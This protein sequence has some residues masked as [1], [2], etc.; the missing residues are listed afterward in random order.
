MLQRQVGGWLF[1]AP[2]GCFRSAS[3]PLPPQVRVEGVVER[4]PEAESTEYFHSRPRGS[5]V[6][7]WVSQQSQP[8]GGRAALDQNAEA[9]AAQ[10]ADASVP[11]PKPPH[12]GGFLI[13]PLSMEFWQGR[14]SRLHDRIRYVR[15]SVDSAD[16]KVERLQP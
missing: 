10:Y 11:V 16:W 6:G 5:Q 15:S 9:A 3:E 12:W 1:W 4:L 14:P 13:R 8:V 2:I 7:A